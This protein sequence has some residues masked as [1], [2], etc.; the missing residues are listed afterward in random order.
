MRAR[1]LLLISLVLNV[2]LVSAL[3][4]WLSSAPKNIP[5]VVRPIN[6]AS[7]NS[8]IV[9]TINKT[10]LLIRPRAFTWQEIESQD[11]AV[12]VENLRQLGMPSNTI[13]DIIV[14]DVDQLFAQRKRDEAAKQDIEWWRST[15]SFESQS[16]AL[17]RAQEI[18]AERTTLLTKLLGP[19]W[20]KGRTQIDFTPL[21]LAGP[22][23]GNLPDNVKAGVQE[24]AERS[25]ARV[26]AYIGQS[27]AAGQPVSG[28]E[29]ARLREETRQQLAAILSPAQL[30]EFLLRY[31]E[32]ANQLRRELAGLNASPE[33]FRTLFRAIDGIDRELQLRSDSNDPAV[34]NE[35]NAL[36]QQRLAAVRSALKP[37]RFAAYQTL[38]DPVYRDALAIAQQAGV[39]V[40]AAQALYDISRATS[41]EVNRIRNDATLTIAQKQQQIRDAEAEQQR[42]RATVLG[43]T[44]AEATAPVSAVAQEPQFRA[45]QLIPGDTLGTLALRYGVPVSALRA[46]NPGVDVNRARPGTVINVPPPGAPAPEPPLPPGFRGRP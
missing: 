4:T 35:R 41:D 7:V 37:D 9:R 2:A 6:A 8:N 32:N 25:R 26:A 40:E 24:I 11:Y 46:A 44:T 5:R 42:A 12:Y 16:N 45:H 31:S 10:N 27:Q 23:L 15:P 22:V 28:T 30:E 3:V 17:A 38:H 39:G 14:A 36:E 13:R 18:D 29:L 21:P 20:D 1:T 43:E 34:Q 33:E 19:D